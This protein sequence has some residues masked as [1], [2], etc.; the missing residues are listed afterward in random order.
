MYLQFPSVFYLR[1]HIQTVSW[2]IYRFNYRGY[3]EIHH[4]SLLCV[5]M[6]FQKTSMNQNMKYLFDQHAELLVNT[7]FQ[8]ASSSDFFLRVSLM[9]GLGDYFRLHL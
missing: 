9:T 8:W 6:I 7:K 3:P 2:L 4:S 5:H 1:Q